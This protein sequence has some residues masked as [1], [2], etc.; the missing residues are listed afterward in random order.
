VTR[1]FSILGIALL[2]LAAAASPAQ[3]APSGVPARPF[4]LG[5]WSTHDPAEPEAGFEPWTPA[6]IVGFLE[7]HP[8]TYFELGQDAA[9]PPGN[10]RWQRTR[11]MLAQLRTGAAARGVDTA[12]RLCVSERPDVLVRN[13][14]NVDQCTP[15]RGGGGCDWEGDMD[16]RHG[17]PETVVKGA[18][19]ATGGAANTLEHT[20]RGWAPDLYAHRLVVVRPG[21]VAEE[22]R[23]VTANDDHRLFVSPNWQQPPRPG[24]PYEVRGS[25]DPA[26]VARVPLGV[27][28]DT[29]QRYWEG[30]RDVCDGPCAPPVE[31]LDPFEAA[32][33]F[34]PWVDRDAIS[35][36]RTSSS[37]P[38]LYGNG[39][40]ADGDAKQLDDP[41]FRANGV[42]M[43]LASREYRAWRIRY[44]L[45]KIEDYGFER[46][47]GV[48]LAIAY[49][50]GL[51]TFHDPLAR[52]V[53]T[54]ACAVPGT[55]NWTGPA[56]VCNDGH[57][58]GGP[59]H[60][61]PYRRGE[62]EAGISAYFRELSAALAAAGWTDVRVIT[63]EAP[64]Y[65]S[66][67]WAVLSDDVR[68]LPMMYG[69]QGGWLNPP[70]SALVD[71]STSVPSDPPG[72]GAPDEL[73]DDGISEPADPVAGSPSGDPP[74]AGESPPPAAPSGGT[75]S[76]AAPA[77]TTGAP[78]P[79]GFM[80]SDGG[81]G[82][83][84]VEPP[85]QR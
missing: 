68:R 24:D 84:I 65:M 80:T 41:H 19:V 28:R 61:T 33:G 9:K 20:G 42:V 43:N 2:H 34:E 59:F 44:L 81:G 69:E 11:E 74:I 31:P 67:T 54:D 55:N 47:D 25:F 51:H 83:G 1:S 45:Y 76:S 14:A 72:G 22:R 32:R 23:R 56:H 49:K 78:A 66:A 63:G 29:V 10:R 62:F 16:G 64:N 7:L 21:T 70:L 4:S 8:G 40:D 35:A 13:A 38:V 12:G 79:R 57:L 18:G 75:S 30:A 5:N 53:N 50:P 60:P 82:G 48:C 15:L 58:Q 6:D 36:L 3:A 52:G 26:W 77:G 37:V 39:Y 85:S 73:A 27:H 71:G 46:G 17:E